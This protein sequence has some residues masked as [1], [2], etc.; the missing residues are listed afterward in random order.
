[1]QTQ[2]EGRILP[3]LP[4]GRKSW[5][6][7]TRNSGSFIAPGRIA[8]ENLSRD[9]KH[10]PTSE[11]KYRPQRLVNG[12]QQLAIDRALGDGSDNPDIRPTQTRMRELTDQ[13]RTGRFDKTH[14]PSSSTW[15]AVV[16]SI[17]G[18]KS[19]ELAL[20]TFVEK[21]LQL[22]TLVECAKM[23]KYPIA[24]SQRILGMVV[25]K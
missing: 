21:K 16:G 19:L 14:A 1:M 13:R 17:P 8:L 11:R 5:D 24:D 6:L 3:K 7:M 20:E 18:T 2:L 10:I 4:F 12:N 25:S 15:G 23:W 9:F 22:D